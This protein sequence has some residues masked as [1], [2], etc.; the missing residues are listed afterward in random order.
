MRT[1][2]RVIGTGLVAVLLAGVIAIPSGS[3]RAFGAAVPIKL[4]WVG[5]LSPPGDYAQGEILKNAGIMATEEINARGGVLGRPIEVVYEDTSGR[6]EQ[7]TAAM[8]RLLTQQRVAAV[9]GEYHSS[10]A[11][12]EIEL[13]HIAGIPWVGVDVWANKIT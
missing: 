13:A 1:G 7:G 6:P 11:L 8:E 12:A 10:V 3:N 9:F 5:P 2:A 4:G